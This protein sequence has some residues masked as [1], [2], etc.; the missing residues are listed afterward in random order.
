[1]SAPEAKGQGKPKFAMIMDARKCIG[2]MACVAA[3][4]AEHGI[5]LGSTRTRVDDSE[6]GRYPD[7]QR[8]F[9]AQ[10]C[11][12]CENPPCIPVCPVDATFRD[13]DG[14]VVIDQ[15]KCIACGLCVSACP[16]GARYINPIANCAD[17]CDLCEGRRRQGLKPACVEVCPT[18]ARVF[19]TIGEQNTEFA[20]LS[21]RK[22]LKI[23]K[24]EL[25]TQPAVKYIG[26]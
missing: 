26:L 5:P 8:F 1:M 18:R 14:L 16:Y 2:C 21:A 9:T 4:K 20:R 10:I 15:K 17:K 23:L 12:Q 19:G 3:C 13:P 22:D 24:P 25:N 7:T 11:N 6:R